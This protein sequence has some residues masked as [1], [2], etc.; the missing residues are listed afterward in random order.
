MGKITQISPRTRWPCAHAAAQTFADIAA[1]NAG[2]ARVSGELSYRRHIPSNNKPVQE[3]LLG[4]HTEI[5]QGNPISTT[6]ATSPVLNH[7]NTQN[8]R[9][10]VI[11]EKSLH[12]SDE[13]PFER[14]IT[15]ELSST[16]YVSLPDGKYSLSATV[17]NTTGFEELNIYAQSDT[18]T[19][20][21]SFNT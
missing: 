3:Q 20:K 17:K 18:Q 15:Q 16:P 5:L 21:T 12:I 1:G 4:W 10:H 8:D 7:F 11:G 14:R 9:Q 6:E 2:P 13:V 19:F